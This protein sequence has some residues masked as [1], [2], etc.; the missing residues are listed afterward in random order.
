M[1]EITAKTI[2]DKHG[3]IVLAATM[4]VMIAEKLRER[5]KLVILADQGIGPQL[6]EFLD[7]YESEVKK[8]GL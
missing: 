8:M 1:S 7:E 3:I 4:L 6:L 5:Q 2:A